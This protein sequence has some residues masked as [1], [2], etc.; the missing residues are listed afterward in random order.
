MGRPKVVLY[1]RAGCHLCDDM[2]RVVEVVAGTV[3]IDFHEVDI[4]TNDDLRQKFVD[5]TVP[6]AEFLGLAVPD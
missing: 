6:Q 1:T 4:D 2:K 3:P 5:V